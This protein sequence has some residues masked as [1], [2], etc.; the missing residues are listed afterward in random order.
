MRLYLTFSCQKAVTTVVN[1]RAPAELWCIFQQTEGGRFVICYDVQGE[2]CRVWYHVESPVWYHVYC[3]GLSKSQ[4]KCMK[5]KGEAFICPSC[6]S[7]D[8]L[9]TSGAAASP[10]A[11]QLPPFRSMSEPSF[12][13]GN[14]EGTDFVQQISLAYDTVVHWRRNLLLVPFGKVGRAFVQE[15]ARLFT[16]YGEGGAMEYIAIKAAMVMCS[17]L[18]QRPH[19]SAKTRDFV[20]SLP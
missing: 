6:M 17:L 20:T 3:V 19:R 2:G 4:G 8:V 12:M 7:A 13:W 5:R 11:A 16:A 15:L 9:S 18:L 10:F 14:M 1:D